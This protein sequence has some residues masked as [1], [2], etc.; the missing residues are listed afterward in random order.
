MCPPRGG[1]PASKTC[2]TTF[3]AT[4]CRVL[5]SHPVN[6]GTARK[7]MSFSTVVNIDMT[8]EVNA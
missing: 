4:P 8:I 1:D 6:V 7:Y 3:S 5:S 2:T